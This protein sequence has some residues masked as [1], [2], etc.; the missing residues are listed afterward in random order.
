MR[1]VWWEPQEQERMWGRVGRVMAVRL[2][3]EEAREGGRG[4][5]WNVVGGGEGRGV[6]EEEEEVLSPSLLFFSSLLSI[7]TVESTAAAVVVVIV[8]P[9]PQEY[10]SPD[11]VTAQAW[12][13][14]VLMECRSRGEVGG[15]VGT[16]SAVKVERTEGRVEGRQDDV[17]EPQPWSI[18]GAAVESRIGVGCV[19]VWVWG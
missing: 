7:F 8:T 2:G 6:E 17:E 19:W 5:G 13:M 10:S 15:D 12:L 14:P 16:V 9:L 3:R 11:F 18:L 4:H 1:R